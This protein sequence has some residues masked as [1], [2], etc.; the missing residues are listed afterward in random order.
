MLLLRKDE[1]NDEKMKS[2]G[3]WEKSSSKWD[4]IEQSPVVSFCVFQMGK[5]GFLFDCKKKTPPAKNPELWCATADGDIIVKNQ[6]SWFCHFLCT[7]H[8]LFCCLSW[9]RILCPFW[10]LWIESTV[11]IAR[12]IT[13]RTGFYRI[14]NAMR[15]SII[16]EC[17]VIRFK[18]I[19]YG[20]HSTA[21][22]YV[23][24]VIWADRRISSIPQ[25]NLILRMSICKLRLWHEINYS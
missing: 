7:A 8:F 2:D 9:N 13:L 16:K 11:R 21:D 24:E 17:H 19:Q 6:Q 12:L 3:C 15:R 23:W 14:W 22:S 25:F 1:K 4:E 20:C 10:S 18:N 5:K